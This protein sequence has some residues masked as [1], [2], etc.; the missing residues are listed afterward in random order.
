MTIAPSTPLTPMLRQYLAIKAQYPDALL[1]FRLGDFY[2]MF[3]NDADVAAQELE[4][5]L[6]SRDAGQGERMAMC[7]VPYH[8]AKGYI[9]TLVRKGYKVAICD[10]VEDPKE[11]K[12]IVRREVTRVVTPGTMTDAEWLDE[13]QNNFL[14]AISVFD[15]VMGLA[16]VDVST[17]Q[18]QV[19]EVALQVAGLLTG[20]SLPPALREELCRLNPKEVLLPIAL[21]EQD[22]WAAFFRESLG[23]T[24][25]PLDSLSSD[26]RQAKEDLL[27][28][29]GVATLDGF[30][31][32]KRAACVAAASGILHYLEATNPAGLGAVSDL[33]YYSLDE[34]ML[35]D[36]AT[37]R[38]LELTETT[39]DRSHKGSLLWLL[40]RSI[41][42]M[43]SRLLRSWVERPLLDEHKMQERLK[44]TSEMVSHPLLKA[45]VR[46]LLKGLYDLERLAG[47]I[48][49]GTANA[50]DMLALAQS[51]RTIPPLKAVLV[52]HAQSPRLTHLGRDL[53]GLD[54]V[55]SQIERALAD[56]PPVTLTEG[57]LIREGYDEELD[58]LRQASRGGKEWIAALESAERERTGIKSLKVGFNKVF[59]Y[60]LEVTRANLS[61]VPPE[62]ERRQTLAQAERYVTSALKEKEALVLGAEEKIC[63]IEY[64]LFVELRQRIA[65][66]TARLQALAKAVA[67]L[68]VFAA[69]GDVAVSYHFSCPEVVSKRGLHLQGGRHPVVESRQQQI[70][71][72]PNDV[73]LDPETCQVMILTGPNMAGKSTYAKSV[74]LIQLMAQIGS[75]VP[76]KSARLGVVDR[77]F[78]RMG[79]TDDI[80]TGYS[81][82]MVESIEVANIL[83]HAT[84][85]SLLLIDEL[86]RGTSTYDGV[87]L[88][89]AVTEFV[90]DKLGALAIV[91]THYHELT[92]LEQKLQRARNFHAAV[93]EYRGEVVF[94]YRIEPGGADRSYGIN[95]AKMAGV[96]KEVIER[97]GKILRELERNAEPKAKL[98]QLTFLDL[99]DVAASSESTT[100]TL[101][102]KEILEAVASLR[103]DEITPLEALNRVAEWQRRLSTRPLE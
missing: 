92:A 55:A 77:I 52:E 97:A 72:V 26:V 62:W 85:R 36:Q 82:F 83:R 100:V 17:G 69:L 61:A 22:E 29:L 67:E 81:T 41:T 13:R 3:G 24:M 18:F 86:G 65:E 12:G 20:P 78:A 56:D 16:L 60:Y 23:A 30:D 57:G 91:S 40:D 27:R 89:Q 19:T 47:R 48:A 46:S 80:G 37:R 73:A 14:V 63:Q 71:F 34:F 68:D 93:K 21:A 88:A 44:A 6:T 1:F 39:R 54:D 33:S 42:A 43:G 70:A 87:A 32:E 7:G 9:G 103:L 75:W 102:E 53:D 31:L 99:A 58:V 4:I 5:V 66:H 74:A 28:H 101:V 45:E 10:Q 64:R 25:V 51:L 11:A 35:L 98:D 95:V 8:A 38:N 84:S 90:H 94:L 96:P 49:G 15:P 2:E 59:G 76:A 50:R 79:A